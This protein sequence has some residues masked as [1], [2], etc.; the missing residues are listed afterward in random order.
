M[1]EVIVV[2]SGKGG[3]GKSRKVWVVLT[4]SLSLTAF[5]EITQLL[6]GTGILSGVVSSSL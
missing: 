2:T 5:I 3:V 1:S 4:I 6:T